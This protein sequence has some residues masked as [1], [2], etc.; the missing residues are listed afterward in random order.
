MTLRHEGSPHWW[1]VGPDNKV[2]DLTAE[3]FTAPVPYEQGRAIG[4]LTREPSRRAATVI[5]RVLEAHSE[6]YD[7]AV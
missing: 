4:F 7:A 1:L 3:Q 6:L 5:A 2:I